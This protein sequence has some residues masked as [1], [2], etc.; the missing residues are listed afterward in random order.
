MKGRRLSLDRNVDRIG[1]LSKKSQCHSSQPASQPGQ[2]LSWETLNGHSQPALLDGPH[3]PSCFT[4]LGLEGMNS[5]HQPL[6]LPHRSSSSTSLGLEK[7]EQHT[8][9][10]HPSHTTPHPPLPQV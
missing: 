6:I 10:T 1:V 8:P 9:A 3:C 4:S 5:T 2:Q 7:A